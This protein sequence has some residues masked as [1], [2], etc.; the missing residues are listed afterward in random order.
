MSVFTFYIYQD[1]NIAGRFR[2]INLQS[3]GISCL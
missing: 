2:E 1:L 3:V